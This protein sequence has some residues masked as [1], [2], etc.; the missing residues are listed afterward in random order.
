L[1]PGWHFQFNFYVYAGLADKR[2]IESFTVI[3][4]QSTTISRPSCAPTLPGRIQ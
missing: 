3:G 2:W 1:S 4:G